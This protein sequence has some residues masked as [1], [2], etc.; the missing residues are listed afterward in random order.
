MLNRHSRLLILFLIYDIVMIAAAFLLSMYIKYK[1]L[2]TDKYYLVLPVIVVCWV[3]VVLIFTEENFLF[4]ESFYERLKNE[5][6]DFLLFTGIV[7]FTLLILELNLYSRIIVFGTIGGFFVLRN[8]GYMLLYRYLRL[9]RLKGR[10]VT[11]LLVLGAGRIGAK[12]LDYAGSK[13]NFG[14]RIIGFLD[15]N[16]NT[17]DVPKDKIIG[18]LSDLDEV[19]ISRSIDEII[20]A[21][22]FSAD[23]KI[24]KALEMADFHG[25]RVRIIPDYYRLFERSFRT[26]QLGELPMINVRQIPLDYIFHSWLKRVFDILF[27]IVALTI[28]SP[29]LVAI[30]ISIVIDTKGPAFYKPIRVGKGGQQFKCFKFRTMVVTED[31][32]NNNRSTKQGDDRITRVGRFLRKYNLDELPQ[33]I[34]VLQNSMSVVGPRPHRTFLNNEMQQKVDGYMIRHYIKPGIT[35]WA[36]VNGWRGPT[37]TDEQKTERTKHDLWYIEQWSFFLDLEIIFRTVFDRKSRSNAF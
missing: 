14:Y 9:T 28:L 35:G 16:P 34:N 36:Q 23:A 8:I 24:N 27:S 26:S 21:L 19:L 15:D 5:F 37:E 3:I 12:L 18:T 7:S 13:G 1:T 20:I 22:P 10:H 29:V 2:E 17:S 33:F 25:L 4:R 6:L 31:P 32:L 30:A 11:K